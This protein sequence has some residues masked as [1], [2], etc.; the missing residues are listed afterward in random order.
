[1]TQAG[2]LAVYETGAKLGGVGAG[3]VQVYTQYWRAEDGQART[4]FRSEYNNTWS[5]WHEIASAPVGTSFA[6]RAWVNFNGTGTP[7]IRASGN[8]S[9]ITDLGTGIY[10]ITLANAMPDANY[11]VVTT[12]IGAEDGGAY[13]AAIRVG[14]TLSTTQFT[15]KCS[16]QTNNNYDPSYV[17][18]AVFR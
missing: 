10:R 5:P 8:V 12:V 16:G 4:F 2:A 9:S 1:V 13:T 3:V 14:T 6:C 17:M 11:T 18:V 15:L 7:S